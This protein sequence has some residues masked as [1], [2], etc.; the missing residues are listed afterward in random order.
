MA[1]AERRDDGPRL[2]AAL[3][4][5][6]ER[7]VHEVRRLAG[8]QR[9]GAPSGRRRRLGRLVVLR[10]EQDLGR[11]LGDLAARR[12]DAAVEQLDRVRA[13]GPLR[14]TLRDRRP[15]VLEPGEAL[16]A[17][18][19]SG[20]SIGS[21]PGESPASKPGTARESASGSKQERVSR[22]QVGPSGS[23]PIRSASPSQSSASERSRRTWPDDSP[24]RHSRP[25]DREWKWTSPG[26][27]RR[28]ERLDVH[29]A[30]H[31]HPTVGDVLDDAHDEAVAVPLERAG[32]DP[33]SR[34][35]GPGRASGLMRAPPCRWTGGP[36]ARGGERGLDVADRDL[37]A[38]EDRR[39]EDGVGAAVD[40][41]RDHVR[42]AGR[43]ARGDDRHPDPRRDRAQELA[44]RSRTSCRRGRS[45]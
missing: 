21:E 20:S 30:D 19:A 18:F 26:A 22:W 36:G 2:D 9:R 8:E 4:E 25:R 32:I 42:G 10:R 40:D 39:G 24:L 12:V 6:H 23:A 31:Q 35:R 15:Q 27:E 3:G 41:R 14:G 43:A 16:P 34:S 17:S 28:R 11:L 44:C 37:A 29:P 1:G 33:A 7:V 38:V 45:R 13:V 5:Q